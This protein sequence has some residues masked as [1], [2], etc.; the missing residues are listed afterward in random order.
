M[1]DASVCIL[2]GSG[3]G[4][5]ELL[6]L[7]SQHPRVAH[8]RAISPT[9]AGKRIGDVHPNLRAVVETD[10][11]PEPDWAWLSDAETPVLFSAMPHFALARQLFEF[12]AVWACSGLGERL[13][14]IDLSGDF[15][16]DEGPDFEQAYGRPHPCPQALPGFVYGLPEWHGSEIAGAKRIANPGCFATAIQLALLPLAGEKDLGFIA[17][18]AATGS[19]GSGA[20]ATSTTHH[21][22]RANDY[23]AYKVLKHQHEAEV[24]RL[25][26]SEGATGYQMAFVP[27]SAPVVRGIFATVQLRL[28]D[29]AQ[30]KG[31]ISERYADFYEQMPFVRLVQDSPRLAAVNGSNFCDLSVVENDGTVVILAALDNLIKGMAG[32]AIQNMNI[33]LGYPQT[34]GLTQ[35]ALYPA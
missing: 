31:S 20:G 29:H 32:Q 27:H 18:N 33:A 10:F 17:V 4:G 1:N 5:G 14:L 21:P 25:L 24:R 7:L 13:T 16:L 15:R 30:R 26:Q 8:V 2:G 22:V 3:Y 11:Y 34:C 6:R 12:Q 23:R 35:P 19:S 9:Y 28:R